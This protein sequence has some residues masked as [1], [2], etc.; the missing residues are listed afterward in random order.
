MKGETSEEM[1]R[2][3]MLAGTRVDGAYYRY[4]RRRGIR[5]NTLDLLYALDDGEEHTQAQL[6]ADWLIPK[7]TVNTSVRELREAGLAELC[8][9]PRGREKTI[10]LTAAGQA[11]ARE[12]LAPVYEVERQAMARALERYSREFVDAMECFADALCE[13][14]DRVPGEA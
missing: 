8:A 5:E 11:Y 14:F 6:C 4:A 3:L 7:T 10:R 9:A 13:G 1:L 2:R 12:A